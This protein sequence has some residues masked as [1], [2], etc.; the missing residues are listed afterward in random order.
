MFSVSLPDHPL[1]A[2]AVDQPTALIGIEPVRLLGTVGEIEHHD[3][4]QQDR[5][6]ALAD[7][8]PLPAPQPPNPVHAKNQPGYRGA[9]H[10]RYRDRDHEASDHAGA[11]GRGEPIGQ[12]EDD[13]WKE[14]GLGSAEEEA[15]HEEARFVPDQSHSG[16]QQTPG[17]HDPGDPQPRPEPLERQIARHFEEEVAEKEDSGAP[18]EYRCG[19]AE[20]AVHLQ[21]GEADIDPIEVADE[22]TERYERDYSPAYLADDARFHGLLPPISALLGWLGSSGGP[23][24]A[25]SPNAFRSSRPSGS[26]WRR[27]AFDEPEQSSGHEPAS[28]RLGV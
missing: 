9:D 10:R 6:Q 28:M 24:P 11:I 20:I 13:P 16:R 23:S 7:E 21:C 25:G 2:Q 8:Q 3:E 12:E 4:T 19:E 14:A 22:V 27:P 17:H 26:V 5:R 1:A 18:S 15:D